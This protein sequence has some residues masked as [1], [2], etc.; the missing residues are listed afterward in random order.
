MAYA[1]TCH[2]GNIYRETRECKTTQAVSPLQPHRMGHMAYPLPRRNDDGYDG[3]VIAVQ[4]PSH[5]IIC[6]ENLHFFTKDAFFV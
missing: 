5:I 4:V 2:M 1:D 6:K 3:L